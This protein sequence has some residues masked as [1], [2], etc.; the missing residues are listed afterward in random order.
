[1]TT[2]GEGV[3]GPYVPGMVV[4]LAA[5]ADPGY[6]FIGWTGTC[7]DKI[8]DPYSPITTIMMDDDCTL[9]ANF[10]LI[11]TV[12]QPTVAKTT[13][14]PAIAGRVN[15]GRAETFAAS[16]AASSLGHALEY[17]F[18]WGDGN[19]SAWGAATQ[20]HT[21]TYTSAAGPL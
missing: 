16:D 9:I 11:E 10:A 7:V 12:S 21:Y 19:V 6:E 2:P 20:T 14:A 4:N 5:A 17:Q 8:A 15:S 1:V 13:T 3:F 18:T